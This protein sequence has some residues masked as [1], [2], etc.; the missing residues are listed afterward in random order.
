MQP[1]LVPLH[2]DETLIPSKLEKYRRL[3]TDELIRSLR[4][5]QPGCLK[6]RPDGTMVDG[7]ALPRE[8]VP[9]EPIAD[10]G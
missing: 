7:H 10:P 8:G 4:P 3:T 6:T 2:A 5:G 9:K 1:P